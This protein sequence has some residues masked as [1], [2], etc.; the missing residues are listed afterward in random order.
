MNFIAAEHC[1]YGLMEDCGMSNVEYLVHLVHMNRLA[2]CMHVK[3]FNSGVR[4]VGN[5]N[6]TR[7][8]DGMKVLWCH[9]HLVWLVF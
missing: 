2:T 8:R 4:I 5:L 1:R 3:S 9:S 7:C 6:G